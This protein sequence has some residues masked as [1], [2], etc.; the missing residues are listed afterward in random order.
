MEGAATA[1]ADQTQMRSLL[2]NL[3]SNAIRYNRPGGRVRVTFAG[4]GGRT[5]LR[6]TDT[7]VGLD[8]EDAARACERFWR[9]DPARSARDGRS[10]LGLAI[11]KAIVD[12]HGGSIR[13][14]PAADQGTTVLVEL[15]P[16]GASPSASPSRSSS[17]DSDRPRRP[18]SRLS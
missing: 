11:S 15:P 13:L 16:S 18:A 1:W 12:A 2:S 10:G 9:A 14:Q 8:A 17:G 7:G 3:L 5:L 6:V 4:D